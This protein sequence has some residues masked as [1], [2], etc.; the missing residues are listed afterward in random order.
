MKKIFSAICPSDPVCGLI[1][2]LGVIV[3]VVMTSTAMINGPVEGTR[4]ELNEL[5]RN[6]LRSSG[7]LPEGAVLLSGAAVEL[8]TACDV[9]DE[10]YLVNG[11]F[12]MVRLSYKWADKSGVHDDSALFLLDRKAKRAVPT[13]G[14]FGYWR[15]SEVNG[16]SY[17]AWRGQH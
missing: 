12:S 8:E 17:Y 10:G 6:A 5:S 7:A 15:E 14:R 4:A 9:N 3:V 11:E 16:D 2:L 13:T 1:A